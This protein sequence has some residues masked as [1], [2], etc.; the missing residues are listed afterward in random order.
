M[1]LFVSLL[2]VFFCL[3]FSF[4]VLKLVSLLYRVC[5]ILCK[6]IWEKVATSHLVTRYF[7]CQFMARPRARAR[8]SVC[9][10]ALR[11]C[12]ESNGSPLPASA[13]ASASTPKARRCSV[14]ST[15]LARETLI[16]FRP[17][18]RCFS[19]LCSPAALCY[20][21]RHYRSVFNGDR[22]MYAERDL[23]RDGE[24]K[25]ETK[26]EKNGRKNRAQ[27]KTKPRD[28]ELPY[29]HFPPRCTRFFS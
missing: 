11:L 19:L 17:N 20:H 15:E 1:T 25:R 5:L 24:R 4:L 12:V 13:A 3:Y 22:E 9:V 27:R 14:A 28:T 2:S 8:V 23:K 21:R 6:E 16:D 29:T 7:A 26:A 18:P 10:F